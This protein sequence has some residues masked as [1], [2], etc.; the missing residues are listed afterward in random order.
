MIIQ[1]IRVN[2]TN[3]NSHITK[4]H[5]IRHTEEIPI[6]IGRYHLVSN[7][8][9]GRNMSGGCR[10]LTI[11]LLKCTCKNLWNGLPLGFRETGFSIEGQTC[12]Y[13]CWVDFVAFTLN[14]S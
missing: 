10:L 8:N 2:C 7:P 12:M 14:L 9:K 1:V 4:Y 11:H 3:V 5:R 13:L 6:G